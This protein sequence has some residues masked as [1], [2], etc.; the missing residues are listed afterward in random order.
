MR[1]TTETERRLYVEECRASGKPTRTWCREKG[2]P[3]TTFANW[4]KSTPMP[5]PPETE[6]EVQWAAVVPP[7]EPL[8][9]R[10]PTAIPRPLSKIRLTSGCFEIS[11]EKGFDPEFLSRVLRAVSK[12]A[13]C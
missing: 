8:D 4:A 7:P 13:C 9:D 1:K 12:I 10:E 5:V 6:Q 2:I 3:Y 11:V